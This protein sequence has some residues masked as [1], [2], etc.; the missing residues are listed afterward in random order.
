M[1]HRALF[2]GC[3]VYTF[4]QL[5]NVKKKYFLKNLKFLKHPVQCTFCDNNCVCIAFV[6]WEIDTTNTRPNQK[7]HFLLHNIDFE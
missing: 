3:I 2:I 5:S 1:T 6:S 4:L 7:I